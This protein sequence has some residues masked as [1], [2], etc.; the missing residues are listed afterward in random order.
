MVKFSLFPVEFP[1]FEE[2]I[3]ELALV[4]HA[5]AESRNE[6]GNVPL[7]FDRDLHQFAFFQERIHP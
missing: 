3:Q 1:D 7:I 6:S 4:A 5:I 2:L